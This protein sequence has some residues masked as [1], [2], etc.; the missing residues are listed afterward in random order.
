[1]ENI[2]NFPI[3]ETIE[4]NNQWKKIIICHTSRKIDEYLIGL[5]YRLNKKYNRIPH[6][7]VDREGKIINTLETKYVS[8]FFSSEIVN[9]Q[10]IIISL[11]N[12]GWLEKKPLKEAYVNWLGNI[13]NGEVFHKSWRDYNLWQPYTETQLEVTAKLCN[14]LCEEFGINKECIGTN[15]KIKGSEK[16]EGILTRSNIHIQLTDLSPAFD[17]QKFEKYLKNEQ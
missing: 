4:S 10:S 6:F 9:N 7:L 11:E 2:I 1:M 5:K 3:R 14:K 13:Y 12:L 8:N 16:F 17:F 15:T